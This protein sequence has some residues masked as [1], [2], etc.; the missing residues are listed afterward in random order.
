MLKN[1]RGNQILSKNRVIGTDTDIGII[2]KTKPF[3]FLTI[4]FSGSANCK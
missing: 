3:L 2:A 4:F 1:N